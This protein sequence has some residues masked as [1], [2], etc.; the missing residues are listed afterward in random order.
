MPL[1][2]MACARRPHPAKRGVGAGGA[3]QSGSATHP[4]TVLCLRRP[5]MGIPTATRPLGGRVK[6]ARTA[7]AAHRVLLLRHG[8]GRSGG[9]RA[10]GGH[11]RAPAADDSSRTPAERLKRLTLPQLK[12]RAKRAGL[13]VCGIPTFLHYYHP[14]S[15]LPTV[16]PS[17]LPTSLPSYPPARR[18]VAARTTS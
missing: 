3:T 9:G 18:L 6:T 14:L 5:P 15:Y 7:R 12:E 13:Q 4:H 16:P 1:K 10:G 11:S 2:E 17:C 8:G